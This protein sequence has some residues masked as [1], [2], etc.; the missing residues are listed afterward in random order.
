MPSL[1]ALTLALL[2]FA[3]PARAEVIDAL[4]ATINGE[5][6]T[7]YQVE[8][9]YEDLLRQLQQT[10]QK[11]SSLPEESI[12]RKRALDAR[13]TLTLQLQQAR[14]LELSTSDE[15]I[16][17]TIANI[18]TNN[19]IPAGRLPEVLKTQGIDY[20]EYRETLRDQLTISKLVNLDVR[21]KIQISEEAMREF[22]RKN[23]TNPKPVREI[24]LAQVYIALPLDP[25]PE[26]VAAT[27][28]K[29]LS[30]QKAAKQGKNFSRIVA[31]NSDAPD[32]RSGGDMGWVQAGA[33]SPQFASVAALP[34]GGVSDPLRSSAGFHIIKVLEE[35]WK[36][37]ETKGR[38]YD[39][40]HARHILLKIPTDADTATRAKIRY[41][42]ENI[43]REMSKADDEEFATRAKEVSQG[44]SAPRGG[45]LGWFQRGQMVPE[46][47]KK[48]FA[49]KEGETSG[50]VETQFGLHIIRLIERRHVDPNS[51]EA[52]RE[53]IKETLLNIDMQERV[54]RW[55][56]GLKARATIEQFKCPPLL[57]FSPTSK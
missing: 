4:A 47:E 56:A 17:R 41:R 53:R 49:M 20:D 39:E 45:D 28:K 50:I 6:I 30:V 14:Q 15:D 40:V 42:A 26:E 55:L 23:I 29:A 11:K 33:L 34:A 36:K 52:H 38:S 13:I 44:P 9:S 54:P 1:I 22:Y 32:A 5:A 46:F 16:D 12:L 19:G 21:S 2:C 18:E 57:K 8:K 25:K 24:H 3:F 7:C 48:V 27:R 31:L 35:R 43:A 51:F 37:P 10:G